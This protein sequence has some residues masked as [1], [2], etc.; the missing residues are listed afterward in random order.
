[1]LK[2]GDRSAAAALFR[3]VYVHAT[4]WT[5]DVGRSYS[6]NSYT[7]PTG[8]ARVSIKTSLRTRARFCTS[9]S[10]CKN[11][12]HSRIIGSSRPPVPTPGERERERE[13][14]PETVQ[15]F[16]SL[17]VNA[18]SHGAGLQKANAISYYTA[19]TRVSYNC[20]AGVDLGSCWLLEAALTENRLLKAGCSAA[21]NQHCLADWTLHLQCVNAEMGQDARTPGPKP[22]PFSRLPSST[23]D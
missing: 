1:M 20:D 9:P 2:T 7:M 11:K 4:V 5:T 3:K 21:L 12:L 10:G 22:F 18:I 8:A 19:N 17:C 14:Q 13:P 23:A 6:R 15:S 16:C